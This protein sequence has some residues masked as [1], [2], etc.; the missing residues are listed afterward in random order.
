MSKILNTKTGKYVDKNGSAGRQV[1]KRDILEQFI[2]I[3]PRDLV[4]VVYGY[5]PRKKIKEEKPRKIY[6][7]SK[8]VGDPRK[9]QKKS[10]K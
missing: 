9:S 5:D 7:W 1:L 8:D 10:K 4:G 2:E 3:L 6:S